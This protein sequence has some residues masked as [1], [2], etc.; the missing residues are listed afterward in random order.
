M[1]SEWRSATLLDM[2][3]CA[4]QPPTAKTSMMQ[5]ANGDKDEKLWDN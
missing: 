5:N 2:S 3:A 1:S 4:G